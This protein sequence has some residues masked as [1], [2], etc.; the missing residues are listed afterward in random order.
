MF[1]IVG[2][3]NQ[4]KP[5]LDCQSCERQTLSQVPHFLLWD[6]GAPK[7]MWN[8]WDAGA[9]DQE[10][11]SKVLILLLRNT[12]APGQTV[13]QVPIGVVGPHLL[14]PPPLVTSQSRVATMSGP[15]TEFHK[16]KTKFNAQTQISSTKYKVIKSGHET[17]DSVCE[18][19]RWPANCWQRNVHNSYKV[20]RACGKYRR[21]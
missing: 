8:Y 6:A 1:L 7:G 5:E 3:H 11:L 10:T 17:I 4:V 14:C 16:Q 21:F 19:K 20:C 13:S 12:G 18:G 2:I 15:G 9:P